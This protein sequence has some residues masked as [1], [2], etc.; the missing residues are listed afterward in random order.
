MSDRSRLL[1]ASTAAI[2]APIVILVVRL[3]LTADTPDPLPGHWNGHGLSGTIS[4]QPSLRMD[5]HRRVVG[6]R[7]DLLVAVAH[8]QPYMSH[9]LAPW[10]AFVGWLFAAAYAEI[11]LLSRGAATAADVQS[12]VV[13]PGPGLRT[14]RRHG[15]VDLGRHAELASAGD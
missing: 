8:T 12:A 2:G 10:A 15:L 13:G 14:A 11:V 7:R 9:I 6:F 4:A 3:T 1:Y 5:L